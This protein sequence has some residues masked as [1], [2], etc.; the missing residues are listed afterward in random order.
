MIDITNSSA[1]LP[2]NNQDGVNVYNQVQETVSGHLQEIDDTA[3]NERMRWEHAK[4]TYEEWDANGGRTVVVRGDNF[5]AVVGN[6]NIVVTGQCNI[7][8]NGDCGILCTQDLTANA[9]SIHLSAQES[10]NLK[11]GTSI[12]MESV[13]GDFAVNSGGGYRLTVE[14]EANERFKGKLDTNVIGDNDLTIGGNFETQVGSI[15]TQHA[16]AGTNIT[17]GSNT[18]LAGGNKLILG[19]GD[20]T[21]GGGTGA[22]VDVHSAGAVAVKSKSSTTITSEDS[23][24]VN[25][26]ASTVFDSSDFTIET[27]PVTIRPTVATD[28]TITAAGDIVGGTKQVSINDHKHGDGT[29]S[30]GNTAEPIA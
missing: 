23:F 25:S 26:T 28:S 8:V 22:G 20:G 16:E 17:S 13:A 10:I 9:K 30:D 6:N 14:G 1:N 15:S 5:E 12:N 7:T 4:G 3:G 2:L 11:A 19:G 27:G 24:A 29:G 21:A 18:M